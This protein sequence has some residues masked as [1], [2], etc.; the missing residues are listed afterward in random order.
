MKK[1][2][3]AIV[4]IIGVALV[5]LVILSFSLDGIVKSQIEDTG[6]RMLNTSVEVNDASISIL[7]GKGTI[8]G[9]TVHNPKGFSDNPAVQLEQISMQI[10]LSSLLSDTIVVKNLEIQNPK[11]YFEQKVNGSNLN[12][13]EDNM[14]GGSSS[15]ANV[16][17]DYL[18]VQQ[19]EV[20][21]T[22]DIGGKKTVKAQFDHFEL[23]GIGRSGNS[24]LEQTMRQILEP[25][26]KKA[27]N[28]AVKQGLLDAA[29]KK[30]KD[31]IGG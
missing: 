21:L 15:G 5:G 20:T 22:T 10:D 27:A 13:L 16:V 7:D 11:I 18:L 26:L 3:N 17:V 28:E 14:S 2:F 9:I 31:L 24:T 1:V 23:N 6:S 12:A 25:I 19:G 30:L 29:K 8:K 4:I